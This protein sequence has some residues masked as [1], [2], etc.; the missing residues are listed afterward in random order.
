MTVEPWKARSSRTNRE[1]LDQ[2]G[3]LV[4]LIFRHKRVIRPVTV[5]ISRRCTEYA[6]E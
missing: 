6:H 4:Q 1:L 3:K 5:N 2:D